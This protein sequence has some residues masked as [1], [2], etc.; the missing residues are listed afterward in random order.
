MLDIIIISICVF[1]F[2]RGYSK[3]VIAA[4]LSLVAAI[5][6]WVAA[7]KL[8]DV[9]AQKLFNNQAITSAKWAP[10][11]TH[12]LIFVA[13]ILIFR[14]LSRAVDKT[15]N[16][17]SLSWANKL[18]GG[19]L[20]LGFAAFLFSITLGFLNK[21]NLLNTDTKNQSVVY[22][23]FETISPKVVE[24]VGTAMPFVKDSYQQLNTL[25]DKINHSI[26]ADVDTH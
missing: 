22:P 25:F 26:S 4:I 11:L 16:A 3:G 5:V 12:I 19:V 15:L 21:M 13:V 9:I 24:W 10:L 8:S 6:A 14:F 17:V 18:A 20:Y 2:F 1:S 7:L 23:Y